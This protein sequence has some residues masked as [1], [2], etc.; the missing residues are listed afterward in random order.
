MMVDILSAIL[1]AI[2]YIIVAL[3][4]FLLNKGYDS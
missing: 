1:S 4:T 3:I 2:P